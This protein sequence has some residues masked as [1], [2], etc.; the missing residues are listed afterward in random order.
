MVRALRKEVFPA[1]LLPN[2]GRNGWTK[3]RSEDPVMSG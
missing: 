1:A 3:T 2:N